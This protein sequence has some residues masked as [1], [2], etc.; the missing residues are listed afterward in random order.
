[1]RNHW[2]HADNIQPHT[3]QAMNKQ[4]LILGC[5]YVGQHLGK[6]WQA[7]G[8]DVYATTRKQEHARMLEQQGLT[9]IIVASPADIPSN[10]L[11]TTTH[12]LDS[13]PLSRDNNRMFA[14]QSQWLPI[15]KQQLTQLQW[16]G[17]LS[18]TG[19]YGDAAGAWVD[20]DYACKPSSARGK[21][22]LKAEQA[23]LH[24]GLHAEVFRLAGIYGPQR[25]LISRLMEGGYK[26]VTWQPEHYSSR[27]HIDDIV[28]ALCAAIQSPRAGRIINIADDLPLPHADYVQQLAQIIGAPE[29]ILL[30][31]E[32][33]QAQLSATAL[34]F[35]SDNKRISNKR[36]HTELL[37]Q[38]HY[39]SFKE[40]IAAIINNNGRAS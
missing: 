28:A 7:Q 23:W 34:A 9:P 20:E 29:P 5:G 25:N 12:I 14:S 22:R 21:E 39:P 8:F 26:A 32:Q 24:S 18:T 16:A 3:Q 35:F 1:M 19:V 2:T 15:L 13:I 17:Y 38:L 40:G 4:L 27:I 30:S 11:N 31:P 37:N 6:A 33:G 10:I 36:L